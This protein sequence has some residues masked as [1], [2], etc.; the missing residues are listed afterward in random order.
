M[1]DRLRLVVSWSGGTP[2]CDHIGS[3]AEAA[4]N[5]YLS[6]VSKHEKSAEGGK[7][8]KV[9]RVEFW[10]RGKRRKRRVFNVPPRS[11]VSHEENV[12]KL[13]E[14]QAAFTARAA[15]GEDRYQPGAQNPYGTAEDNGDTTEASGDTK[16]KAKRKTPKGSADA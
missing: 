10:S 6:E 7:K 11:V 13:K 8:A 16:K 1:T 12:A 15:T 2:S 5:A 14:Q 3:D 9:D 4:F